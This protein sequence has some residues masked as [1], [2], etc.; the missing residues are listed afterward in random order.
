MKQTTSSFPA[1]PGISLAFYLQINEKSVSLHWNRHGD[2]AEG[3]TT[4]S[5][6]ELD[7]SPSKSR[8]LGGFYFLSSVF[9]CD[10]IEYWTYSPVDFWYPTTS[11]I[12]L[13]RIIM[14][15]END[16]WFLSFCFFG[17]E[18]PFTAFD[19]ISVSW[20]TAM[21]DSYDRAACSTVSLYDNPL[22]LISAFKDLFHTDFDGLATI[23]L[24]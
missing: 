10:E 6:Q 14:I 8:G 22:I 15:R 2:F 16:F 24:A 18:D 17:P 1:W 11:R 9:G 20:N 12:F 3:L 19:R 23:H 4:L 21:V 7:S 5:S 13:Y